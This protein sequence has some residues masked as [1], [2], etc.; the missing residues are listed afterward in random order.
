[1]RA[2][3]PLW[4]L[5]RRKCPTI[6]T[7]DNVKVRRAAFLAMNQKDVLDAMIGD[8]KYYRI[9]GAVFVCGTPLAT[10]GGADSLVRGNGMAEAKRM[11]ADSGYDGTP[12]VIMAPTDVV[13]LK[14][15][16]IVA[17]QL[18]RAAGFKVDVQA[19]DWQTVVTRRASQKPPKE[20]GWN[21][22]FTN[23][24]SVDLANPIG[25]PL[26]NGKGKHG[27]WFGWPD[28]PTIEALRDAFARSS[29]PEE[30]KKI[31]AEIQHEVFDYV[32]YIPLGQYRGATAWRKSLSGVLDGPAT[33]VFWN[34]D[35]SQ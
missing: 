14:A 21:I 15:Q 3:P 24:I 1:V 35:K 32:L 11:I 13:M 27:G 22:F 31:A 26:I 30:Q 9:C 20:G 5:S 10:E 33:P 16:P 17:A 29:S 6:L 2:A 7:N 25:N 18:L 4:G 23:F 34:I 19:A 12:V 8:P 28:N